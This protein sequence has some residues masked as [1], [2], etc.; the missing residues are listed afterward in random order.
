MKSMDNDVKMY[1]VVGG[2]TFGLITISRVE[3]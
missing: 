1:L 2:H 3:K